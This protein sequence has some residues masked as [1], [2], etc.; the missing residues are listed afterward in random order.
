MLLKVFVVFLLST[1]GVPFPLC[2]VLSPFFWVVL[3]IWV[4]AVSFLV[5]ELQD[6]RLAD[7]QGLP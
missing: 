5:P 4:S 1:G 7:H 6:L 2:L 3:V